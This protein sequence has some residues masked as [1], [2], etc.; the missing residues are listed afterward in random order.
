[1][2][3]QH[4]YVLSNLIIPMKEC[5]VTRGFTDPEVGH[6]YTLVDSFIWT[7]SKSEHN[8]LFP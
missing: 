7:E 3:A 4:G 5:P 6:T 2:H 1:M 8:S